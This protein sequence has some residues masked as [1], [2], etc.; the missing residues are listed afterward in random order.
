MWTF[1]TVKETWPQSSF[2]V[3][4]PANH[5]PKGFTSHLLFR[6][7]IDSI[8][9]DLILAPTSSVAELLLFDQREIRE[10]PSLT[11]FVLVFFSQDSFGSTPDID[12][13]LTVGIASLILLSRDKKNLKERHWG[14][15][16]NYR[17]IHKLWSW[18]GNSGATTIWLSLLSVRKGWF[19]FSFFS[20]I[21]LNEAKSKVSVVSLFDCF[22][23]F[24]KKESFLISIEPMSKPTPREL[25]S[26]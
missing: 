7:S 12:S 13:F 11:W 20:E 21:L 19:L 22:F 17:V 10:I 9:I 4:F 23:F 2:I 14:I 6:L 25:H 3:F 16:G 8:C 1:T 24:V 18:C 26:A 5:R 15:D